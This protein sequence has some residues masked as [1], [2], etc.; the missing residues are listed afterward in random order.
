MDQVY[1]CFEDTCSDPQTRPEP[2]GGSQR[3]PRDVQP[4]PFIKYISFSNLCGRDFNLGQA[5]KHLQIQKYRYY[6]SISSLFKMIFKIDIQSSNYFYKISIF[7]RKHGVN[8]CVGE[9]S[10]VLSLWL[11]APRSCVCFQSLPVTWYPRIGKNNTLSIFMLSV[12]IQFHSSVS[13]CVK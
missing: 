6:K 2:V 4:K 1:C 11:D 12:S 10:V 13:V 3:K 9:Y 7:K 5:H 8:A